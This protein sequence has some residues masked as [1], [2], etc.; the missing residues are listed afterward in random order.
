MGR[1]ERRTSVLAGMGVSL[2]AL[3]ACALAFKAPTVRVAEIRLASMTFTGGT[4]M[5]S[6]DVENPNRY[7]L[8]SREFTYSITFAKGSPGGDAWITLTRGSL[9]DTVRFPGGETGRVELAV[10]FDMASLGAAVGRLLRQGELEYRF[11]GQLTAGTPLGTKR[12]P[13][14]QRGTFRP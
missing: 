11:S 1:R 12:I 2:L 7:A 13:F 4:L 9:P 5:V 3:G 8:E 14:D 6:L 10:P